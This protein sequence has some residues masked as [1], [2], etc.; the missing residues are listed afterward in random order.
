MLP[1]KRLGRRERPYVLA[2]PVRDLLDYAINKANPLN[3]MEAFTGK[4]S[5]T[6][7]ITNYGKTPAIMREVEADLK[8]SAGLPTRAFVKSLARR[9]PS[10]A[11]KRPPA[12]LWQRRASLLRACFHR[13]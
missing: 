5:V 12:A 6:S 10:V 13:F 11:A 8:I 7:T 9:H 1:R 3:P 2:A 4:P